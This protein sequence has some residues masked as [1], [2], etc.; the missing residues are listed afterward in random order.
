MPRMLKRN[1]LKPLW[2]LA[3]RTKAKFEDFYLLFFFPIRFEVVDF[4]LFD[5]SDKKNSIWEEWSRVYE[6]EFVLELLNELQIQNSCEIHNT[7]WG[8]GGVHVKFKNELGKVSKNVVNS[9]IRN[10]DLP[11]TQIYDLKKRP[12]VNWKSKFEIVINVSTMEEIEASHLKILKN[13]LLMVRP[14]GYLI[15][16]FD[17]P[18]INLESV[19]KLFK[20]K[21]DQRENPIFLPVPNRQDVN[22]NLHCGLMVV[23]RSLLK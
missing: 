15:V 4:R 22:G 6:Y 16:T 21:L 5:Y 18:G 10:S 12:P 1:L 13:L 8:Y 19:E 14:G 7:C 3:G 9:D 17:L 11:G 2:S 20:K 23:K